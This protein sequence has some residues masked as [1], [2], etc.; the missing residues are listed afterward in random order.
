MSAELE[1]FYEQQQE[2]NQSCLLALR[3]L[4]LQLDNA[5]NETRKWGMPCFC[6][7]KK[8]FCFLWVDKDTQEPYVLFVEGNY[9][10]HP[11]LEQGQRSRMKI[12]RVDPKADLPQKTLTN[13]LTTALDLY[14]NGVI[15]VK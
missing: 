6:Y 11:L 8:M 14:R 13:L 9:L 15:K 1:H 12:F 3:T 7:R 10:E 4:I 5:V 2:P